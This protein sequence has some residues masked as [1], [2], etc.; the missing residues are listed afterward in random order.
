MK[1]S[2]NRT[3]FDGVGKTGIV[4]TL[5]TL[6]EKLLVQPEFKA[7]EIALSLELFTTGSLDIFGHATCE[8]SRSNGRMVIVTGWN[9]V[10]SLSPGVTINAVFWT[11]RYCRGWRVCGPTWIGS[12]SA[13]NGRIGATSPWRAILSFWTGRAMAW[14]TMLASLSG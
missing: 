1:E 5:S 7:Q 2:Y 6:R 13:A 14:L 8:Y 9:G 4:P 10:R 11:P 3:H 12:G